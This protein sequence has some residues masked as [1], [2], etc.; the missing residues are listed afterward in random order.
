MLNFKDFYAAQPPLVGI[1][2]MAMIKEGQMKTSEENKKSSQQCSMPAPRVGNRLK[3]FHLICKHVHRTYQ[4][5]A[6]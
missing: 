4:V 1:E 5:S 3:P 6:L 2:V